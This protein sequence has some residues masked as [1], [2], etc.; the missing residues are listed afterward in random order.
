MRS[1]RE[2][3]DDGSHHA[4][5]SLEGGRTGILNFSGRRARVA[6]GDMNERPLSTLAMQKETV[7]IDQQSRREP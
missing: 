6:R 7:R 3:Q 5:K 1:R 2:Q 4:I